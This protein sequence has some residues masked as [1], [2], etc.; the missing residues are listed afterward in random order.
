[1]PKSSLKADA[2]NRDGRSYAGKE[3]PTRCPLSAFPPRQRARINANLAGEFLLRHAER[4]AM[5]GQAMRQSVSIL[6]RIESEKLDHSGHVIDARGAVALLP[7]DDAHLVATDH[8]GHVDLPK[9]EVEPALA[10][11][12]SDGRRIGRISLHLCKMG[13]DGATNHLYCLKAKWQRT[14]ANAASSE[15]RN[16]NAAAV[17]APG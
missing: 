13:S 1:M 7:I 10:D 3:R 8:F 14:H 12:L 11:H 15:I 6:K 17:E 4:F 16:A 9:S 2:S 5:I